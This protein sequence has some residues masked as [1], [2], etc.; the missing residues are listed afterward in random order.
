MHLNLKAEKPYSIIEDCV[1]KLDDVSESP[2]N[3]ALPKNDFATE[4]LNGN[5]ALA[6]IGVEPFRK[7]FDILMLIKRVPT[8]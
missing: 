1:N 7:I 4:L 5:P 6:H 3:Y 8:V 2:V